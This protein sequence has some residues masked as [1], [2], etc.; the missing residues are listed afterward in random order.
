MAL[1]RVESSH[2]LKF[3]PTPLRKQDFKIE[4]VAH[5]LVQYLWKGLV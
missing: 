2:P 5:T 4:D 1:S 3:L